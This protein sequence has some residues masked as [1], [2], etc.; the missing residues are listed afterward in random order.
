MENVAVV[1]TADSGSL[2]VTQPPLSDENGQLAATLSTAGNRT[3]RTITVTALANTTQA[4]VTVDVVGTTLTLNGPTSLP[5]GDTGNFNV[6]M[7]DA[8]GNGFGGV[9]VAI[10][11]SNG[12]TISATPLTTDA[13]GQA[14]FTLTAANGGADSVNAQAAGLVA[15]ANV[16]V[17][18]DAFAFTAPAPNT[19]IPLNT[20]QS[21][22]VNWQQNNVAVVGQPVSFSSTPMSSG[23]SASSWALRFIRRPRRGIFSGSMPAASA[24]MVAPSA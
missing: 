20:N 5:L 21:V 11:S 10:T 16:T 14:S 17:S 12:N 23:D 4:T 7:T 13:A 2:V 18:A 8:G 6:V 19:E 22:T 9:P 1:F 3:N 24:T 15:I